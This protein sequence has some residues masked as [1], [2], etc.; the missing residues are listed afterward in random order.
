MDMS[1]YI[2]DR[3]MDE[4]MVSNYK[5]L[6]CRMHQ[7]EEVLT[8][9]QLTSGL[10]SKKETLRQN[11]LPLLNNPNVVILDL[12]ANRPDKEILF[13]TRR[14]HNTLTQNGMVIT[15]HKKQYLIT[16]QNLIAEIKKQIPASR[17]GQL[18]N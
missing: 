18:V 17:N 10:S 7:T 12:N 13:T 3:E 9:T 8:I 5:N 4:L 11:V 14:V 15:H 6:D 16:D 1:D 2:D